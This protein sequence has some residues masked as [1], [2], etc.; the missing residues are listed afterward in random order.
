MILYSCV[1][2]ATRKTRRQR[3][4]R[5]PWFLHERLRLT[6]IYKRDGFRRIGYQSFRRG[7]G[8]LRRAIWLCPTPKNPSTLRLIDNDA[9]P[10]SG[11]AMI[12]YIISCCASWN[13]LTVPPGG[14]SGIHGCDFA[15]TGRL[16]FIACACRGRIRAI[17]RLPRSTST[18]ALMRN[19]YP[20]VFD[21]PRSGRQRSV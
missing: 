8:P 4:N 13:P 14:Y 10:A 6:M 11:N 3:A 18:F 17:F 1:E 20:G 12:R 15:R 16:S 19:Q 2:I 21:G 5:A 9:K 7:N